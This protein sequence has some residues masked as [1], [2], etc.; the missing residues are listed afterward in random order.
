MSK[1]FE[2][3]KRYWCY[4]TCFG[5]ILIMKRTDKTVWVENDGGNRWMMRVK[6]DEDGNELVVDSSV[7]PKWR[8]VF[9]YSAKWEDEDDDNG[10]EYVK[11]L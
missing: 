9:T 4:D 3:G 2:V 5:T 6:H 1:T 11:N 7:T 10:G 8:D